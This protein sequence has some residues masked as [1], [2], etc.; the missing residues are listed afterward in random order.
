MRTSEQAG[1]AGSRPKNHNRVE[2]LMQ[3]Q[4]F[5]SASCLSEDKVRKP[6]HGKAGEKCRSQCLLPGP[7]QGTAHR[8]VC[9]YDKGML[10]SMSH[11]RHNTLQ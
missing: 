3:V 9:M 11:Q 4:L 1:G 2:L 6:Q 8:C 10:Q 5:K 7:G